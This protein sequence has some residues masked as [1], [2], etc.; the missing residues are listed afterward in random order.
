[1]FSNYSKVKHSTLVTSGSTANSLALAVLTDRSLKRRIN[2]GDEIITPALTFATSVYPILD[3]NAVP[4]LVDIDLT[5]LNIDEKQI[6]KAI[7]KK[8]KAIMPVHLL[9]N[10][11]ANIR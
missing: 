6:E 11:C 2:P 10:K 3:I 4:V 9:G 7:T 5:T 8:T 1:M